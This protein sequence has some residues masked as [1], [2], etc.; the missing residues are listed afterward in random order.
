MLPNG[1]RSVVAPWMDPFESPDFG[2]G[3]GVS[4]RSGFGAAVDRASV[5]GPAAARGRTGS[6]RDGAARQ[7]VRGGSQYDARW[8]GG[9]EIEA[10][11]A[12][13]GDR[14]SA[15]QYRL[16]PGTPR[17]SLDHVV[18]AATGIFVIGAAR[19]TGR[20]EVDHQPLTSPRLLVGGTDRTDL[21]R[22]LRRQLE[23]VTAAISGVAP[24]IAIRPILGVATPKGVLADSVLPTIRPLTVGDCQ[25]LTP[26]RLAKLLV[27]PGPISSVERTRLARVVARR[28]PPAPR[29]HLGL[30]V[31]RRWRLRR[32][33]M[34]S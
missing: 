13:C 29:A 8:K 31:V 24:G 33:S 10:A 34:P 11:I 1:R 15:V 20:V 22:D 23:L 26:T 2:A 5:T 28:F 27:E 21:I 4:G 18:V 6:R 3:R 17:A 32:A 19:F 12:R 14:V 9:A 7:A 16:V 30:F 25:L